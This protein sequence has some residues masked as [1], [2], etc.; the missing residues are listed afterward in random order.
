MLV[1]AFWLSSLG[2][3]T[4]SSAMAPVLGNL[5]VL[6]VLTTVQQLAA[7]PDAVSDPLLSD[8]ECEQEHCALNALQPA[9]LH[10]WFSQFMSCMEASKDLTR[11]IDKLM[12][13]MQLIG[14][15]MLPC[16]CMA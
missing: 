11:P 15:D 5:L 12:L 6:A 3:H 8:S 14:V 10:I 13:L 9:G 1:N 16:C 7:E 2:S 4:Q